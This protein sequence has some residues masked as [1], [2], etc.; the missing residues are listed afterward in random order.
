MD[1]AISIG[2]MF[3]AVW[4]ARIGLCLYLAGVSQSKNAAAAVVR[5]IADVCVAVLA[6]WVA[7]RFMLPAS[8]SE[9]LSVSAPIALIA[10]GAALGSSMGRSRL[11]PVLAVSAVLA[12][13]VVPLAERWALFGWLLERGFVDRGGA[14]YLHLVG[15]LA[16]AAGAILV[17]PRHDK[18]N[19]DGSTNH[20]PAHNI[21]LAGAGALAMFVGIAGQTVICAGMASMPNCVL[22]AAAGGLATMIYSHVRF[23]AIDFEM[24]V[25]GLL[26]GLISM[27]AGAGGFPAPVAVLVGAAGGLLA[28]SASHWL[29]IRLRIDDPASAISI[30]AVGGLWALLAAGILIHGRPMGLVPQLLGAVVIGGLS[31]SAATGVLLIFRATMGLRPGEADELDGADLVEHDVNAYPDF[32]QTMIKSHHLR[33]M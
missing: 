28:A 21:P 29:D 19:H 9:F 18:Y 11:I 27:S 22:A 30:H 10:T 25:I 3:L 23:A 33:Q 32:Q 12:G 7:G 31:L 4:A 1:Q 20:I 13:I 2:L 24:I 5:A 6:L 15:G 17:G 26:A 16:G 8:D 14:S